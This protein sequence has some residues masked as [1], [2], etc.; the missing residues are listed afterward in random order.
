M[1]KTIR[2]YWI[3]KCILKYIVFNVI[4]LSSASSNRPLKFTSDQSLPLSN[5]YDTVI[6]EH[7]NEPTYKTSVAFNYKNRKD[8][9]IDNDKRFAYNTDN[10]DDDTNILAKNETNIVN[11]DQAESETVFNEHI[12]K[13]NEQEITNSNV[14]TI[15]L[16]GY[17][18]EIIKLK[19]DI[20]EKGEGTELLI[21]FYLCKDLHYNDLGCVYTDIKNLQD[22]SWKYSHIF[23]VDSQFLKPTWCLDDVYATYNFPKRKET[24]DGNDRPLQN[25]EYTVNGMCKNKIIKPK[26][27]N[28]NYINNIFPLKH[29]KYFPNTIRPIENDL[30]DTDINIDINQKLKELGITRKNVNT[31][32]L[33]PNYYNTQD[34]ID[35]NSGIVENPLRKENKRTNS[36]IYPTT[37]K[38][39]I[40]YNHI[41]DKVD[42]GN[43]LNYAAIIHST[44]PDIIPN[45]NNDENNDNELENFRKTETTDVLE[46]SIPS[47]PETVNGTYTNEANVL[48]CGNYSLLTNK[49]A[50]NAND[51]NYADYGRSDSKVFDE[52]L[53]NFTACETDKLGPLSIEIIVEDNPLYRNF[54]P[55]IDSFIANSLQSQYPCKA[56]PKSTVTVQPQTPSTTYSYLPFESNQE[57]EIIPLSN[58]TAQPYLDTYSL[59]S[60]PHYHKSTPQLDSNVLREL[61]EIKLKSIPIPESLNLRKPFHYPIFKSTIK[62]PPV[63]IPQSDTEENESNITLKLQNEIQEHLV[64]SLSD[65]NSKLTPPYALFDK[66]YNVDKLNDIIIPIRGTVI[67]KYEPND[68]IKTNIKTNNPDIELKV[69]TSKLRLLK[70]RIVLDEVEL[71][72]FNF[73]PIVKNISNYKPE[74]ILD[75]VKRQYHL[76][77]PR[78]ETELAGV[79]QRC[80]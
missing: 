64:P 45:I 62:T 24:T 56:E 22:V 20:E 53:T 52:N 74:M 35:P 28:I 32:Y 63:L 60:T 9:D 23:C 42:D 73:V 59:S 61:E 13:T 79:S 39:M 33:N 8:T 31:R 5:N 41:N 16:A 15:Y 68:L 12:D 57:L 18:D 26:K 38:N 27:S 67:V 50:T 29:S 7:E 49:I 46:D 51:S 72:T 2:N 55:D 17:D 4:A 65:A 43:D 54:L 40:S 19:L 34:Y 48:Q 75:T 3:T 21:C 36:S 80:R 77:S 47:F 70:A 71:M 25:I 1:K 58:N 66:I 44:E 69:W 14:T 11:N 30:Q 6:S 10:F 76:G 78:H 37:F